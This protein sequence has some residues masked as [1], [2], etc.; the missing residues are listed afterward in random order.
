MV[1][2]LTGKAVET[3]RASLQGEV[4]MRGGTKTTPTDILAPMFTLV[5]KISD[6][7]FTEKV[8]IKNLTRHKNGMKVAVVPQNVDIFAIGCIR[9]LKN[10]LLGVFVSVDTKSKI[11]HSVLKS[12]NFV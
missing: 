8:K 2:L 4:V 6:T 12:S 7:F 10:A 1:A 9:A 5:I 11:R 3:K